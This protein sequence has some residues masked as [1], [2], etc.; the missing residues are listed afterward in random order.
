MKD[1]YVLDSN[2]WIDLHRRIP[3]IL[4]RVQPLIAENKICLVDVIAAEVLRGVRSEG[5]F[6]RLEKAFSDFPR[7]TTRWDRVGRLAF[8][9]ARKGYSPPLIDLY[10]AQAVQETG[11]TLITRDRHFP[12]I[13]KVND[14]SFELIRM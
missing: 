9:V 2:I 8:E 10:I 5:D 11:R 14:L 7:I 13:A 3:E 6:E 4:N 12:E 1:R